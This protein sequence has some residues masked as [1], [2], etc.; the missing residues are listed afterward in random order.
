[1]YVR[2]GPRSGC[3]GAESSGFRI[4]GAGAYIPSRATDNSRIAKAIPGWTPE[5]IEEK[6][7]I[8]ERR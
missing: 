1:V 3:C 6:T 4:A 2:R 5:Q 7:S 8:R